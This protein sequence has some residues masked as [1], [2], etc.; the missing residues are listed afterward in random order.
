M[1]I[2]EWQLL[3]LVVGV[4]AA[5][6]ALDIALKYNGNAEFRES[7]TKLPTA[8]FAR[9]RA[10]QMIQQEMTPLPT[11]PIFSNEANTST[12]G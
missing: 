2:N 1:N 5:V 4:F 3:G 9:T 10:P 6:I 12:E 7:F 8:I 11:D